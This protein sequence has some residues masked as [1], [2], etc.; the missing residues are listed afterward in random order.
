[1][2]NKRKGQKRGPSWRKL[3]TPE[4]RG[5][6]GEN[7]GRRRWERESGLEEQGGER[8]RGGAP[9]VKGKGGKKEGQWGF[10]K[11]TRARLSAT[12]LGNECCGPS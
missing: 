1:M 11:Q 5:R 6:K 4:K 10:Y 7:D 3:K 2:Q 12:T 9:R 8:K